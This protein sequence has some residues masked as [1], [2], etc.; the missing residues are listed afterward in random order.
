M[1]WEKLR[2]K[3][4]LIT[5]AS[6]FLG[7]YIVYVLLSLNKIQNLNIIVYALVR[8]LD[9]AKITFEDFAKEPNLHILHQNINEEI[10]NKYCCDIIFHAASPANPYIT[11]KNPYEVI[12]ANVI[13]YDK[14]LNKC[15]Q[16]NT[17]E[18]VLFSSSAVY[19]YNTPIEGVDE[20]YRDKIDFANS[21]DVYALSK[22]MMEMMSASAN[23]EIRNLNIKIVRPFVVYGPGE[24]FTH[25]K[26]ITDFIKNYLYSENIVLKSKGE[27]TRSYIYLSDA[28]KG[29]FYVMLKGEAGAYNIASES[30]V[31]TVKELANMFCALGK[32]LK[33]TSALEDNE[34]LKSRQTTLVG[35]TD[36][37]CS[38]GWKDEISLIEGLRRTVLWAEN[39]NF[40]ES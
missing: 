25:K 36:K 13:A 27:V 21:G 20:T 29:I 40:L 30:N 22:Q 39:S 12:R 37:L 38:L 6:G 26:A 17:E 7:G 9:N 10:D 24:R 8:N 28:I 35:K 14:L 5:G 16:W 33:V 18:M 32:E 11:T 1:P 23:K 19:G 34:Y 31:Y 4:F 2:N 3:K 15:K